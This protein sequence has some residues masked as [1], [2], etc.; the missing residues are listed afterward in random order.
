[1]GPA[2]AL[3]QEGV[4]SGAMVARV[5]TTYC[6][7]GNRTLCAR[8][9][10][11]VGPQLQLQR[12]LDCGPQSLQLSLAR[13]SSSRTRGQ[14]PYW[15]SCYTGLSHLG[16]VPPEQGTVTGSEVTPQPGPDP[17]A[18]S[19]P[20]RPPTREQTV[21]GLS[22]KTLL[23]RRQRRGQGQLGFERRNLLSK[24]RDSTFS[25]N[26]T[27]TAEPKASQEEPLRRGSQRKEVQPLQGRGDPGGRGQWAPFPRLMLGL[28][29][30][31][32]QLSAGL[33]GPGV[34]ARPPGSGGPALGP[35]WAVGQ[36]PL[37]AA[38]WWGLGSILATLSG[39]LP[40]VSGGR[41]T[42]LQDPSSAQHSA[43]PGPGLLPPSGCDRG[44]F[45]GGAAPKRH[46][47]PKRKD[48]GC[49]EGSS[50]GPTQPD[51]PAGRHPAL[52]HRPSSR[53][54]PSG[55]C[56]G[57]GL[58]GFAQGPWLP[59]GERRGSGRR[60]RQTEAPAPWALRAGAKVGTGHGDT[61]VWGQRG[62]GEGSHPVRMSSPGTAADLEKSASAGAGVP[63]SR[64]PGAA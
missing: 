32:R 35:S 6:P 38:P 26:I 51:T 3:R 10:G 57:E 16:L 63:G 30:A 1:M 22:T 21:L 17:G 7:G 27:D 5:C 55:G 52:W 36:S 12:R 59:S 20:L 46:I 33:G 45:Q 60:D 61:R 54:W 9:P 42:A 18:G 41:P 37:P 14:R 50:H 8:G 15:A 43:S 58:P 64:W 13:I 19:R 24:Q 29:W 49:R 31:H 11:P 62:A 25:K 23:G 28:G 47:C 48:E 34:L 53:N 2:G 4:W 39:P 40:W 44:E 56:R